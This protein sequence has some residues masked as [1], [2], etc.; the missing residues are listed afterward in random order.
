[1]KILRVHIDAYN[2]ITVLYD[3]WTRSTNSSAR[4]KLYAIDNLTDYDYYMEGLYKNVTHIYKTKW[5][6][7]RYGKRLNV[8]QLGIGL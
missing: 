5:G 1:M 6:R 4:I 3:D 2:N 7:R 8:L